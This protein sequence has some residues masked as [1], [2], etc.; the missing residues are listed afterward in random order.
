MNEKNELG[1]NLESLEKSKN[2]G[3]IPYKENE[4]KLTI[5]NL[6]EDNQ[7]LG[8]KIEVFLIRSS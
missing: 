3:K 6:R 5:E 2:Y 1:K 4:Y 7:S 8:K